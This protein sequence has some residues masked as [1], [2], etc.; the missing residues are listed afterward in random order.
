MVADDGKVFH[1]ILP[2]DFCKL[3][4]SF[5]SYYATSFT[6]IQLCLMEIMVSSSFS[7]HHGHSAPVLGAISA[8]YRDHIPFK[9]HR[10]LR[11]SKHTIISCG[12]DI[13]CP[14]FYVM[15]IHTD[16][17][18]IICNYTSMELLRPLQYIL[19]MFLLRRVLN[20]QSTKNESYYIVLSLVDCVPNIKQIKDGTPV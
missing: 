11:V 20:F 13:I 15:Y 1:F 18:F 6:K 5:E 14:Y 2:P 7:C 17:F 16:F 9:L 8:A 10:V 4:Q 19:R 12:V 3:Q